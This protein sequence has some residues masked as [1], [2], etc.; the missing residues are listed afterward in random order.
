MLENHLK[1]NLAFVKEIARAHRQGEPMLLGEVL[2]LGSK[3]MR[4]CSGLC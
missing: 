3:V 1:H 4:Q 2:R